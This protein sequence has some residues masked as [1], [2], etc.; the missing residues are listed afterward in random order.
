MHAL[1]SPVFSPLLSYV[2][3]LAPDLSNASGD[4]HENLPMQMGSFR[5]IL[6]IETV[7]DNLCDKAHTLSDSRSTHLYIK[8][9]NN[10]R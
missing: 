5:A 6:A 10:K 4:E 3:L 8:E 2:L 1:L 9:E 7:L